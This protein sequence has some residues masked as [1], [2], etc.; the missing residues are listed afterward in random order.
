[1]G[2]VIPTVAMEQRQC[3]V[4]SDLAPDSVEMVG[5]QLSMAGRITQQEAAAHPNDAAK[6]TEAISS[7]PAARA[8]AASNILRDRS[9]VQM[10]S[11]PMIR[12]MEVHG[13]EFS[14]IRRG[15]QR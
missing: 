15:G 7:I 6:P 9:D 8:H 5:M 3:K 1:M 2:R 11:K 13:I 4:S 10:S 14:C 12:I